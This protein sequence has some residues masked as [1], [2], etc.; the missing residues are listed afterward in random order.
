MAFCESDRVTDLAF[1]GGRRTDAPRRRWPVES[2]VQ[3]VY[4]DARIDEI[5]TSQ[6]DPPNRGGRPGDFMAAAP[7]GAGA[8]KRAGC[9]P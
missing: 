9:R 5:K 7:Q 1:C 4:H 2:N 8:V 6:T 3:V